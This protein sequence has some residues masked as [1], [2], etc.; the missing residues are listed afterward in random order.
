MSIVVEKE[1]G[2]AH[3][4]SHGAKQQATEPES[5]SSPS[6]CLA[7]HKVTRPRAI[8]QKL[9]H[10][11]SAAVSFSSAAATPE[12][13][14]LTLQSQSGTWK[15]RAPVILEHSCAAPKLASSSGE[16]LPPT[17][18]IGSPSAALTTCG[19]LSKT[20]LQQ[21]RLRK[22]PVQNNMQAQSA[23]RLTTCPQKVV[24]YRGAA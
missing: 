19:W 10:Q 8:T 11:G 23:A 17:G 22:S 6:A 18:R 14:L 5:F 1:I 12:A 16:R 24:T 20:T 2:A 9:L 21:K 7:K 15:L 13:Q 4:A 3:P